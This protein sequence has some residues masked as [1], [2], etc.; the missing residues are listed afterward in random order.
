MP[1]TVE[2]KLLQPRKGRQGG[3]VSLPGG[4]PAPRPINREFQTRFSAVLLALLTVA[5]ATL[6]G[7]NFHKE[8]QVEVPYD[9]V[10]WIDNGGKISAQRVDAEGPGERAGIKQGDELKA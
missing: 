2:R 8:R 7:I 10:W 6:A 9:G 5:A 1:T 4:S 3:S